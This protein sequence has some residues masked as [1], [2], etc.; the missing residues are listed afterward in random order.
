MRSTWIRQLR[1]SCVL[2]LLAFSGSVLAQSSVTISPATL[3]DG[4]VGLAYNQTLTASGAI[5]PYTFSVVSGTPP[6]GL[7][8][9]PNGT[10]SGMPATVG[11][12]SFT[13]RA[14]DSGATSN[15]FQSYTVEIFHEATIEPPD[16]ATAQGGVP[17]EQQLSVVNGGASSYNFSVGSGTLPPGLS[18]STAGLISGTPTTAGDVNVTINATPA[19]VFLLVAAPTAVPVVPL[20]RAY[21]LSVVPAP[22]IVSPLVIPDATL[23]TAYSQVITASDGVAPYTFTTT[24]ALPPG[25]SIGSDGTLAG[26][27]TTLGAY[28]F[29][30]HATDAV[31]TIGGQAYDMAVNPPPLQLVTA[32]PPDGVVGT[33]YTHSFV[34]TGGLPPYAFFADTPLPPGLTVDVDGLLQGTPTTAGSQAFTIT[35]WD[36]TEEFT[37]HVYTLVVAEPVP[38][39]V[40]D[41]ANT[42]SLQAV[43]IAVT[44]NDSG[45][46]NAIAI[47]SPPAQGSVAI[48][49]LDV[50]YQPAGSYFGD[51]SFTYTLSGPGGTS[52]PAT[53]VVHVSALPT[54]VGIAQATSTLAGTPVS[55][56]AA[57]GASAGPI[58]AVT[59]VAPPTLGSVAV[60][61]TSITYTPPADALAGTVIPLQYTL[62]NAYG[63]SAPV[64]STVTILAPPLVLPEAMALVAT[65]ERGVAVDVELTTGAT[66]GPF[67]GAEL[68]SLSPQAAGSATVAASADG[69]RLAFAPADDF[70]GTVVAG[71]TLDNA[72]GTSEP[73]TL[74]ITVTERADPSGDPEVGGLA[75][76]QVQAVRAF[77]DAQIVNAINRLELLHEPGKPLTWWIGGSIRKGDSPGREFETSGMSGGVDYR[78]SDKFAF[79]GGLGYGRDRSTI[80]DNG[81]RADARA[82]TGMGY[83]SYRPSLPFFIDMVGGYQRITFQLRRFVSASGNLLEAPRD[84][85]QAFSSWSSGYEK[86]GD[87]W[88]LSGYARMDVAQAK[89]DG[90]SEDGDPLY[91]LSFDEQSIQTRTRVMGVRGKYKRAIAWGTLEPRFRVELQRDFHD[92]SGVAITYSDLQSGPVYLLPGGELDRNRYII[93]IGTIFKSKWGFVMRLDYRGVRGGLYDDDNAITFSFQDDH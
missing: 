35:V 23:G 40:D 61:G 50:E 84:G 12:Y 53:V 67:T 41:E 70:T 55:F 48:N 33:P 90:Y 25:I 6:P 11:V 42:P 15:G 29:V 17:Y 43:T 76:A 4:A 2:L 49:G 75:G 63:A 31:G 8:L 62:S 20:S 7:A 59:M 72:D 47:A 79:G 37:S 66:G 38:V 56:D 1:L 16:L 21:V 81:S 26:V 64:T 19:P 65:T 13:V 73:A 93:E 60:S 91:A 39:A 10:L 54:P 57:T 22:V 82:K 88:M 24:G 18:L 44:A 58:T 86:K 27:P 85:T 14:D 87:N 5:A 89:L 34:A 77:A 71:Y 78:F 45:I 74:T 68:V 52:A 3:P 46:F 51:D 83:A 30:V 28:S 69:Y 32:N 36:S 9:A 92:E 80:G